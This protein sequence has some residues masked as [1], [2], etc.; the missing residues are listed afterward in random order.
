MVIQ[1][2][3]FDPHGLSDDNTVSARDI[4][5]LVSAYLEE[6][7]EA[8]E[9]HALK[10]FT[11]APPNNNPITQFNRNRLLWSYPGVYGLKTGF[12][13][14]A[15]F[16]MVALCERDGFSTIA[17]VL[18]SAKGKSIDQGEAERAELVTSLF[19]WAY[20]HYTFVRLA[21]AGAD[22]GRVRVWKGRGK[23]TQGVAPDGLYVA[24][25]KQLQEDV[26]YEV[27]F[28]QNLE[29][30]VAKG[31]KVGQAIFYSNGE[32][33]GRM[34]LVSSEDVPKGNIFRVISDSIIRFFRG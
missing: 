7:P 25:E 9:Y 17:I 34:D 33:I 6:H 5:S 4:F 13:S 1:H 28:D 26:T 22:L 12:T 21:D 2:Q 18:G 24:V 19:N 11:Y 30:P 31:D 3:I 27:E 15:G 10:E 20:P 8:L 23:W 32:E 29:A 16:N 14:K